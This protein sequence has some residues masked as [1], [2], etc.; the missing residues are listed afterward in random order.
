[1]N[2]HILLTVLL[3]ELTLLQTPRF[4]VVIHYVIF[5][6]MFFSSDGSILHTPLNFSAVYAIVKDEMYLKKGICPQKKNYRGYF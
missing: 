1:M 4:N 3:S 6:R 5:K 2:K